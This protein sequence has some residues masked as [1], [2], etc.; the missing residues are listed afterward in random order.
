MH[1]AI[2][3]A[4]PAGGGIVPARRLLR[5]RD[6]VAPASARDRARATTG[7]VRPGT[8]TGAR[9]VLPRAA[10]SEVWVG[11]ALA[12]LTAAEALAEAAPLVEWAAAASMAAAVAAAVDPL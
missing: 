11:A 9:R 3:Q 10:A 8:I 4:R 1:G 6:M 12:V 7:P 5:A 2:W